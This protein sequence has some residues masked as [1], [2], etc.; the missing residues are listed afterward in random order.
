M[1]VGAQGERL[2]KLLKPPRLKMMG[3]WIHTLWKLNCSFTNLST[4]NVLWLEQHNGRD[5]YYCTPIMKTKEAKFHIECWKLSITS[6]RK[7]KKEF[8]KGSQKLG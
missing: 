8:H 3:K 1:V 6:H 4:T 7:S 2:P 5:P